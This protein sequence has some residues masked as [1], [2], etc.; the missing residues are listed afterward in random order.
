MCARGHRM[1]LQR[2]QATPW[3]SKH[4]GSSSKK[5]T[6]GHLPHCSSLSTQTA[7]SAKPSRFFAANESSDRSAKNISEPDVSQTEEQAHA[8][9][10]K[11]FQAPGRATAETASAAR[12]LGSQMPGSQQW[13]S[14]N[15]SPP[16]AEPQNPQTAASGN[17][18]GSLLDDLL[19][20]P[21]GGFDMGAPQPSADIA[22]SA[23]QHT[24]K[25]G[26]ASSCEVHTSGAGDPPARRG[27]AAAQRRGPTNLLRHALQNKNAQVS[28]IGFY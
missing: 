8:L 27:F 13:G 6:S 11:P 12:Q 23:A 18:S 25:G 15:R 10:R 5:T 4:S 3:R 1:A 2:P 16:S 20:L 22:P 17:A 26:F 19:D 9:F 24:G 7:P 21:L 28:C 14:G